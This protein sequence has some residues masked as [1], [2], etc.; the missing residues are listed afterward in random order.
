M[1]SRGDASENCVCAQSVHY[2]N[3]C[4]RIRPATTE[5]MGEKAAGMKR[6]GVHMFGIVTSGTRIET[7]DERASIIRAIGEIKGLGMRPC[8]SLGLLSA[9]AAEGTPGGRIVPVPSQ[10]GDFPELLPGYLHHP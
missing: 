5:K 2:E 9:E 10:S 4:A 1:R 7:K 8:A 6:A 3:E